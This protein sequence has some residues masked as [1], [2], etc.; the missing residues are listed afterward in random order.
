MDPHFAENTWATLHDAISEINNRNTSDLSFEQ[1]YRF[2]YNMV[3]HRHG[4]YL[5]NGLIDLLTE[6]LKGVA[7]V[8]KAQDPPAFLP[9]L[10]RQWAWF[11]LSLGHVRDVLM[12]MDRHYVR[13]KQK[14][15]VHELGLSLFR[16]VVVRHP[17]VLPRLSDTLLD[18][19]DRERN[20]EVVDTHLIK[21]NTKMLAELGVDNNGQPVYVNI[22][23]N[24]F[25]DRT[26]HFYAREAK[27]FL[28]E[29]TCSDYL[30]KAHKRIQE[31]R[32]RVDAYLESRTEA[33]VRKVA[34]DELISKYMT[35]LVDMENSGLIWMLRN[36]KVHDLRLMYSLFKD[37]EKGEETLRGKL[38]GE[39]LARGTDLVQDSENV[40]DPVVL[41]N[42]ILALKE[43][44]D[45]ILNVAFNVFA[46]P[47]SAPSSDAGLFTA[48]NTMASVSATPFS[49]GY[50]G[51]ANVNQSDNEYFASVVA[52]SMQ[53]STSAQV[54]S[55]SSTGYSVGMIGATGGDAA[56]S[57]NASSASNGECNPDK[58][59]VS[60]VNEAFERF[61]NSFPR[62][63]EYISLY[64][65]KLLRRDFKTNSD[66]EVESKLD[67]VMTL[68]RYLNEKDIFERYYKLHL[69][70]RLLH[71]RT[72]SSDAERS[73]I[74][75]MK[76]E[77]GY[78]YTSKM[79]VM[80]NDMKVSEE[81][82]EQ[83]KAK[84]A[85]DNT[86]MQGVDLSVSVLTT[87]SWPISP[88]DKANET[89]TERVV[90]PLPI[91]H[92]INKFE[93]YY[94][95]KHEGRRLTWQPSFG[96]AEIRAYFGG[97]TRIVDLCSVAAFSVCILMLF[98][99]KDCMTFQEISDATQIPEKELIRHLQ[100]LS[101][102]KYRVLRKEPREKEVKHDDMFYFNDDFT[103][104]SRRI[105]IHVIAPTK[106]NENERN[107]T[108]GR[109]D[110]DR[111][112]VID[113]VIVRIMKHR[114]VMDHNKLIM[115]VT[116]QLASRFEPNPQEIKKRIESL[117]EREYLER[118][119]DNRQR[120]Q[121]IA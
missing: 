41:I 72:A 11:S 112:P 109:I 111:R 45:K 52:G 74:S 44:Y 14:K 67:A 21:A 4:D 49:F 48:G 85:I 102:A 64:V 75:K 117:V 57:G 73:F 3:L 88:S 113:T 60:A 93:E 19:I 43:K 56:P 10:K 98:N 23:E 66:D 79:E 40:R 34:E 119:K 39:V 91:L 42:S 22:F 110:D 92:C 120:Y 7:A 106:E 2:S 24:A 108:R 31:E 71:A 1:L 30:R 5:Y 121:Y 86:D 50:S 61:I 54:G 97:G 82:T 55:A 76:T 80:F 18:S 37:I 96:T 83:F 103:S 26:K 35:Q 107:Q 70:K 105:K 87:M 9:E 38:K 20:G 12:Y 99:D 100:S 13:I 27:L 58:R 29:T 46:A 114:K 89:C 32:M 101:L 65:D 28:S 69:T 81:T 33:K 15:P 6:H 115:E 53:H 16:D 8:V 90:L 47:A 68:F 36:D 17:A 94:Y 84:V 59:F 104:R 116:A 63:A 78:L 95:G 62:A 51:N 77:C 118:Q 25:L